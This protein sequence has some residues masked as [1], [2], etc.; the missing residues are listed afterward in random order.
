MIPLIGYSDRL[1]GRPGDTISF[2]VS[3]ISAEPFEA[4][5]FRSISADPNPAGPGVI[6][7][8]VASSISGSFPS[9]VQ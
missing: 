3:S 4:E 1:S 8:P 6:E 9:R 5:L 7:R 2:K